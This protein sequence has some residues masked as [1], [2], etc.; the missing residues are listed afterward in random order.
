MSGITLSEKSGFSVYKF[1][2]NGNAVLKI[3]KD[4]RFYYLNSSHNPLEIAEK[5]LKSLKADAS[6][7]IVVFGLGIGY[8]IEALLKIKAE[9]SMVVCIEPIPEVFKEIPKN[10]ISKAENNGFIFL[11]SDD[12]LFLKRELKK[13]LIYLSHKNPVVISNP[14]YE[15]IFPEHF[16]SIT[17]VLTESL[18]MERTSII[19]KK[20]GEH[21]FTNNIFEN[22]VYLSE[23]PDISRLFGKFS[24][25]PA[26]V[27]S[28]GPSLK[29]Q[30]KTLKSLKNKAVII[31]VDTALRV[32]KEHNITPDIVVSIDFTP[33][34]YKHFENLDTSAYVYA[35]ASIVYPK[36]VVHHEERGGKYFSILNDTHLRDWI[37]EYLPVTGILPVGD[38]TS[39]AA[40]H[41]AEKMGCNPI[42][43]IG[44]DLAY[45]VNETHCEGVATRK[46]KISEEDLLEV[47]G[48]Y[49]SKVKTSPA[50]FT[51]LKHFEEKISDSPCKVFNCTEGGARISGAENIGFEDFKN[52]YAA[53]YNNF[54]E[55]IKK[56]V[57]KKGFFDYDSFLKDWQDVYSRNSRAGSLAAK[58]IKNSEKLLNSLCEGDAEKIK[59]ADKIS[60]EIY[61]KIISDY[62]IIK[63][64]QADIETSLYSMKQSFSSDIGI[65][66]HDMLE[67]IRKDKKFFEELLMAC[68]NFRKCMQKIRKEFLKRKNSVCVSEE[69]IKILGE[70]T[71]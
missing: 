50:L 53:V 45:G 7:F 24:G 30:L 14:V 23:A 67:E 55:I 3:S 1:V 4:D 17:D 21:V 61:N 29:K 15:K 64:L 40:F 49:G 6:G 39:H 34:N 16:K 26:V 27:V 60:G 19:T 44:Q 20:V 70:I 42:A 13:Y 47:E 66:K 8:E 36:C 28:A 25:Y 51:I 69:T 57:Q 5:K 63:L 33:V 43:L 54:E 32:L 18:E 2:E 12:I 31:C 71:K 22:L 58:G 38:S 48:Y 37:S 59:K 35:F 9:N 56:T 41:L 52:K 46:E 68:V 62:I 11:V 65:A 10:L